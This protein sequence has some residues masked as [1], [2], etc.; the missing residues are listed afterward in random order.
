[1]DKKAATKQANI[2]K[3]KRIEDLKRIITDYEEGYSRDHTQYFNATD[4]L[5]QLTK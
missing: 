2:N 5:K 4:E 1:M 3:E